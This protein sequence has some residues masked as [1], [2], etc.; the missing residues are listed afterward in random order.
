[1]KKNRLE[2]L[3]AVRGFA[4]L[5]VVFFHLLPQKIL[6]FGLNIGI[7]FRFGPEAVIVFFVLSGFVIKYTWKDL[8]TSLLSI[9][10]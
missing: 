4:A 3:E 2:K 10:L 6:L 7:L 9:I 5:Y 1:M 8:R